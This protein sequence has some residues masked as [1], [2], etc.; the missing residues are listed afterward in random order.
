MIAEEMEDHSEEW[1]D[2]VESTFT[3]GQ[4]DKEFDI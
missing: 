2:I 4:G 3:D 1:S